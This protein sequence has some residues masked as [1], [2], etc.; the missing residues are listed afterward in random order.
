MPA[1]NQDNELQKVK[2]RISCALIRPTTI[3]MDQCNIEERLDKAGAVV[4][5]DI[6]TKVQDK[7]F[8]TKARREYVVI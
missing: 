5:R 3:Y 7:Y 8:R 6:Y 4:T 1:K 2:R